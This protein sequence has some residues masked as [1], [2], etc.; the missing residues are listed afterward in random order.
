MDDF[1]DLDKLTFKPVTKGLGFH[2]DKKDKPIKRQKIKSAPSQEYKNIVNPETT[3]KQPFD[4]ET[5]SR[6]D[7][8]MFYANQTETFEE[9][10]EEELPPI[11]VCA[12]VVKRLTAWLIDLFLVAIFWGVT[13]ASFVIFSKIHIASILNVVTLTELGIF[14]ASLFVLFYLSYF[15]ILDLSI[16]PG[17]AAMGIKLVSKNE[18]KVAAS[19]TFVR[20]LV[21]LLSF[22]FLLL[23]TIFDLQGKASQ[24][25]VILSE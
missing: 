1:D 24:T 11:E 3:K 20:S 16:T 7:L 23:P 21:T 6:D 19:L 17:K 15:T 12:P 2:H 13:V 25:K 8:G 9:P 14:S 4:N 22:A 5:V 18:E 10:R